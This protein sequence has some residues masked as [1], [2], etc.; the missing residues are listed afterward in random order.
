MAVVRC[1]LYVVC[2]LLSFA[3]GLL[4][5]VCCSLFDVVR[6]AVYVAWCPWFVVCRRGVLFVVCCLMV[7][8]FVVEAV[9]IAL[10]CVL[11]CGF[12]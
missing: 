2:C 5:A 10:C 8:A 7:T 1:S 3:C 9:G 12:G 11:L 6:C 4:C